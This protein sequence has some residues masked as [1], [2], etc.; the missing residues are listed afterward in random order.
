MNRICEQTERIRNIL[1]SSALSISP[2]IH[3]IFSATLLRDI[4]FEAHLK[5]EDYND[6]EMGF[7]LQSCEMIPAHREIIRIP[8][9]SG[10]N[11]MD[12]I[13]FKDD[14]SKKSIEDLCWKTAKTFFPTDKFRHD[15]NYQNQMLMWQIILNAYYKDAYN[16][17]MVEA[18]PEKDLTHPVYA[19]QEIY[20]KICSMNLKKFYYDNK[21][22]F[23]MLFDIIKANSVYEISFDEIVWAYTNVLSRKMLIIEP[24]TNQPYEVIMPIIDY[25]NH[26]SINV[27]C[28]YEPYYDSM[29]KV[30]YVSLKAS[31]NIK[32][33][34][35]LFLDYGPMSN[36]KFMNMYGFFDE[37]NPITQ[38]EFYFIGKNLNFWLDIK[39][40]EILDEFNC[41]INSLKDAKNELLEKYS[42]SIEYFNE[43]NLIL[44]PNKFDNK[45]LIFLRVVFLENE[46]LLNKI[47]ELVE[48]DFSKMISVEN[49][50]KVFNYIKF[51]L[52][53]YYSNVKN[54]NHSDLIGNLGP[55][56]T[57]DKFKTKSMYL[58]EKEEKFLLDKNINYLNKKIKNIS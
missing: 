34:E 28:Y 22:F 35:Q 21:L 46:D 50:I 41:H 43:F 26:S 8:V 25:I 37:E 54:L 19:T 15:K 16:H 52:N 9:S 51:I 39:N 27:N 47:G 55:I 45:F 23:Q 10:F 11:G 24:Q 56:D 29:S 42:L 1:L 44:Y 40:E 2:K 48:K 7:G 33:G 3:K 18:F 14:I 17:H 13:D 12:L 53:K 31:R 30:S 49:E 32:E 6:I 20:D 38:S 58:L 5:L 57:V 4:S 36:K